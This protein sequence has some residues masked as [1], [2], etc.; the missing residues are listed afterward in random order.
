MSRRLH[1]LSVVRKA[2]ASGGQLAAFGVFF[3]V[4]SGDRLPIGGLELA[5]LL[6]LGGFLVGAAYQVAYY[7][8]FSYELTRDELRV[9]SGVFARQE[10][11][12]PLDRVQNVDI[13]RPL[14][15][16][17]LGL[18]VVK[19]ETAGGSAT[20]ATL[21]AVAASEARRLQREAGPRSGVDEADESDAIGEDGER[22]RRVGTET[23]AGGQTLYEMG[24]R[25]LAVLS[26]VSF[27][28]GAFAIPF[29]GVPFGGSEVLGIY[30]RVFGWLG[31]D[32]RELAAMDA[33]AL[34]A[35]AAGT[36]VAYL[37]AVWIVSAVLTYLRYYG[38][39]LERYGDELR[40]ERGLLGRYSGTIPL[41][42]VQTVTVTENLVAR[43]VGYAGLAVETAG[44]APG[45]GSGGS[46]TT[47]PLAGRGRVIALAQAVLAASDH[48]GRYETQFGPVSD[49]TPD[50]GSDATGA[51]SERPDATD[52]NR[53]AV[54]EASG[55][56]GAA[57]VTDA[58]DDSLPVVDP[59]FESPA[60]AAKRWYLRRY[61]LGVA[62]LTA[63]TT[64]VAWRASAPWFVGLVPATLGVVAPFAAGRKYAH[65]GYYETDW[66]LLTREGFWRRRTRIVPSF[67]LQTVIRTRT[68]F[69]R[70]WGVASV[71]ADTASSA[72]LTGGDATVHD[73]P[74]AVAESLDAR[75]LERLT[76]SLAQRKRRELAVREERDS[77]RNAADGERHTSDGAKNGSDAGANRSGPE[78]NAGDGETTPTDRGDS[79]VPDTYDHA[80]D[81]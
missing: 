62:I 76:D 16:R 27:R 64:L 28:P 39:R 1:P 61:L 59:A 34:V 20:E 79:G 80:H 15:T 2:I 70:R 9:A 7:Y 40:Y 53:A 13:S 60:P 48:T 72:S 42:K 58:A 36:V 14:T 45:G 77:A 4:T 37:F 78:T 3:A 69:Q 11:E 50:G 17:L 19:F 31:I 47:V 81:E 66:S 38:F 54:S 35:L 75:L 22:V 73:V 30:R 55:A 21:D 25:E 71:T 12:I 5:I 52:A 57:S 65:R 29:V 67:R 56:A 8:R 10:R 41:D 49:A 46:E 68:V 33:V 74:P 43:R 18:A 26:A 51:D 24:D 63:V 44:Y 23:S 32:F 6:A